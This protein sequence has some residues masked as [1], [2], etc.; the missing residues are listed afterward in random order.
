MRNA[1]DPLTPST[2]EYVASGYVARTYD[3]YFRDNQLFEF[4]TELL[5]QIIPAGSR[6]LDLGC[7]TGRHTFYF[8]DKASLVVGVDLSEHM[9]AVC[10]MKLRSAGPNACLI[11]A[12]ICDLAFLRKGT[13]DAAICMFS[14]MG[15]IRGKHNRERFVLGV[16][17]ALKESGRFVLHT[18]NFYHSFL[19]PADKFFPLKSAATALIGRS[20]LGDK[21]LTYYRGVRNMYI[22]VFRDAELRRLLERSGFRVRHVAYLNEPRNAELRPSLPN[23][24]RAN[25]FIFVAEAV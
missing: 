22:H 23:R 15:L 11:R 8:S 13:F 24:L 10:S 12:N 16:R 21:N 18:H 17:S 19:D 9:L 5:G 7:G 25:G 20:E 2:R 3:Y 1:S 4:D 14:T 6:V